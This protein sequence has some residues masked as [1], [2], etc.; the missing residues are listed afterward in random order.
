MDEF[1]VEFDFRRCYPGVRSVEDHRQKRP[2]RRRTKSPRIDPG[3]LR[4]ARL[5]FDSMIRAALESGF[6][7]KYFYYHI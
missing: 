7:D 4:S 1:G 5:C 2:F 3:L 6:V